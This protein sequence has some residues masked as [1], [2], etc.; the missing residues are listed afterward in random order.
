MVMEFGM[1]AGKSAELLL[2]KD[3]NYAL[4]VLGQEAATGKFREVQRELRRLIQAFDRKPILRTCANPGC[5]S[6]AT[7]ATVY[8]GGVQ[9]RWWCD[10]CD[11]AQMCPSPGKLVLLRCFSDAVRY[12]GD[13]CNG[14][15]A[16]LA[17]LIKEMAQARGLP[18]RAGETQAVA[19]F[20]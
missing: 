10:G 19:F 13:W 18:K 7:R 4:W 9:L 5:G 15:E 6:P 11:P 14:R 12:V 8:R 2:I 16:D 3:P 17:V 1:Y 20:R